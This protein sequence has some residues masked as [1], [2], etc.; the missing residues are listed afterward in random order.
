MRAVWSALAEERASEAF[1]YIAADR[2]SAATKWLR[3]VLASVE[4]LAEFPDRGRAV[5]ELGRPDIREVIVQPYRILYRRE[6]KRIVVMTIRHG[7]RAFD[8][9]EVSSEA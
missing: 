1:A 9:D 4:A 3:R 2:P 7:R 8:V 6:P 5:P